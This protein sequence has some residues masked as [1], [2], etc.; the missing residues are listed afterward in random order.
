M[1][2]IAGLLRPDVLPPAALRQ[3]ARGL[4]AACRGRRDGE[5][6]FWSPPG[7]G[8]VLA[9]CGMPVLDLTPDGAQPAVSVDGRFAAQ[10]CGA[11]L[12]TQACAC[13]ATATPN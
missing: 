4:L 2:V 1:S 13:A 8:L 7:I 6:A 5:G 12:K 3:A 10:L 9:H 11:I